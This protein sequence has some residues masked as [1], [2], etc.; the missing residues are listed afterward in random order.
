MALNETF[1]LVSQVSW[2]NL[3]DGT[4]THSGDLTSAPEGAQEFIDVRL[5]A[6]REQEGWRYLVPAVYRYAGPS[7]G[8]LPEAVAGWM[9]REQTSSDRRTY[10][11]ATVVSA[12]ALNGRRVQALPMMVD[13]VSGEVVHLDLYTGPRLSEPGGD[14]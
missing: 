8:D 9:L 3:G 6:A 13:L 11:P 5:E 12:F 10:D 7:F 2:T 14:Q 1:E 4:M